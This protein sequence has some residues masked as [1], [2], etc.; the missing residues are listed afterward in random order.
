ML[1]ADGPVDF[2]RIVLAVI[3]ASYLA[4]FVM[5][6][7]VVRQAEPVRRLSP[8]LMAA[9]FAAIGVAGCMHVFGRQSA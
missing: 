2:P 9:G 5:V 7:I 8:A 6:L 3:T 1:G 4:L